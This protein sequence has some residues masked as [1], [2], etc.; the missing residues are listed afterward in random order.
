M[1]N[2]FQKIFRLVTDSFY[3]KLAYLI[4][5]ICVVSV[6]SIVPG[7]NVINKSLIVWGIFLIVVNLFQVINEK[8]TIYKVIL[9]MFIFFSMILILFNYRSSENIKI[10]IINL[11]LFMVMFFVEKNKKQNDLLKEITTISWVYLIQVTLLTLGS[12]YLIFFNKNIQMNSIEYGINSN[13]MHNGLFFNENA[14]GLAAVLAIAVGLYLLC[15]TQKLKYKILVVVSE[16]INVFALKESNNRSGIIV[17]IALCLIG[18]FI[19][20]INKYIRVG[21]IILAII[22]TIVITIKNSSILVPILSGRDQLWIAA[23][24]SIKKHI[25]VGVGNSDLIPKLTEIIPEVNKYDVWHLPGIESGGLHNIFIQIAAVYG[26]PMLIIFILFLI[27]LFIYI[28]S[29]IDKL[30][31]SKKLKMTIITSLCLGIIFVNF[32]ESNLIYIISFIS[33]V[34]WIYAGYILA[35]VEKNK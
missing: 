22:S 12:L 14:L 35:L 33:L 32:F 25:F 15:L 9:Y 6:F 4:I 28:I 2:L 8:L 21:L 1:M 26:L 31:G 5:S 19:Y 7:I 16:T 11:I 30:K 34:F 20:I 13:G 18:V 27:S 3:F 23:F 24:A 17:L 10:F 29:K